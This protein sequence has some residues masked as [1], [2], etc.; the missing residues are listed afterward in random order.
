MQAQLNKI[1]AQPNKKNTVIGELLNM[2]EQGEYEEQDLIPN[3]FFMMAAGHE[4]TS[5]LI[6][7]GI[8]T[9]LDNPSQWQ[10]LKSNIHD[11]QLVSQAI[12]ELLRVTSPIKRM[13]RQVVLQAIHYNG[14]VLQPNQMVQFINT[15]ANMDK[16]VFLSPQRFDIYRK[17][18]KKNIGFGY[19][20]HVCPGFR[21]A[22]LQMRYVNEVL[23]WRSIFI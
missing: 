11:N 23:K 20:S 1:R 22:Q 17:S 3:I 4:T 15:T 7:N 16:E 9:L 12:D 5:S 2:V 8:L 19:G 21:L 14:L 6:A 10:L 13:T 18:S